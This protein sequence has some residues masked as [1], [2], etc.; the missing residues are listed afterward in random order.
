[1]AL[2]VANI[3]AYLRSAV[4]GNYVGNEFL[5]A[6]PDDCA[7]TRITGGYNPS[8]WTSKRRPSF[9]IVLRAKSAAAAET[10]ANAI[11]DDLH[12]KAAFSLGGTRVVKCV[13]DQSAPIYLG[14]DANG[15]T[16]YSL[17]F[18]LTTI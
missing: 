13:A 11:Y 14:K 18:T 16:Q 8:Q 7:Y 4:P 6:S 9:Q 1:M 5:A 15:R 12:G 17:N 10:Q 3:N 2:T